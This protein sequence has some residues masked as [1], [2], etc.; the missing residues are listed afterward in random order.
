MKLLREMEIQKN[1]AISLYQVAEEFL[2]GKKTIM[3]A[4]I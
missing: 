3:Y 1:M 4:L 2:F